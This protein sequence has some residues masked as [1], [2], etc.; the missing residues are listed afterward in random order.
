MTGHP[1]TPSYASPEQI[2]AQPVSTA[3]DV[4]SLGVVLCELLSG[5]RP[6][7]GKGGS[8]ASLEEAI[9]AGDIMRPSQA[10]QSVEK[11]RA[12]AASVKKLKATLQGDLDKPKPCGT[13]S[14]LR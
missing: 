14:R 9:V 1:L 12:R 2:M 11:A 6:Y 4:Y 3:S 13:N 7:P 8:R 5:E 10:V